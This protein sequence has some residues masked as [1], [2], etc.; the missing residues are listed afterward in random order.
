[1]KFCVLGPLSVVDDQGRELAAGQPLQQALLAMLVLHAGQVVPVD[2][3]IDG[4]WGGSAPASAANSIQVYVSRLRK[5]LE[6]NAQIATVGPGYRLEVPLEAVDA[7]SFERLASEARGAL[8]RG[9]TAK[10]V[11]TFRRALELRR[12]RPLAEFGD[13]PFAVGAARRLCRMID[14]VEED[15][16]D[17]RLA[18]GQHD[19]LP[20]E[21]EGL[22]TSDPLSERR[23]GQLMTALYLAGRQ[24]EALE[25][26]QRAREV[27]VGR[28]GVEPG[29][30]L[31]R[32]EAEVLN[33]TLRQPRPLPS[34]AVTFFLTDVEGSVRMWERAPDAMAAAIARH[35][36][37]ARE[38]I[39]AHGGLLRKTR[40]EGDSTFSVFVSAVDAVRA[41]C[42]LELEMAAESWPRSTPLRVR[43]AVHTGEA[44]LRDADYYG[45]A[46]NRAARIRSVARGEQ[47]L[48]SE[49]TAALVRDAL[50]DEI[51]V[52]DL[53]EHKL[54]DLARPER[55]FQLIGPGLR[56]DFGPIATSEP[57]VAMPTR[58]SSFV[59]RA[60]EL[61]ELAA[62]LAESR[63]VTLTGAGGCGKT[64]LAVAVATST[65]AAHA[66]GVVFV[67]LAAVGSGDL[68]PDAFA[69]ALG[70]RARPGRTLLDSVG[71]YL[72]PQSCLVVVDNCEHVAD[73]ARAVIDSALRAGSAVRVLATSRE[74]LGLAGEVTWLVPPL[75]RE[76]AVELFSQRARAA[77]PGFD[78]AAHPE[79]IGSL[80]ERLDGIP[81]AI[82]L[83]A[84]RVN[85]LSVDQIV[86]R[87]DDA[88]RFLGDDRAPAPTR[89]RTLRATCEW[90][91]ALLSG[92][93]QQLFSCLAVFAG[94][95]TLEAVE[96]LGALTDSPRDDVVGYFVRLVDK[97]LVLR[98]DGPDPSQARYRMLEPLR[99]FAYEQLAARGAVS[100][101]RDLHL[102]YFTAFAET[103]EPNLY[104]SGARRWAD[105]LGCES[106]NI[107]ASLDW[108]FTGD[109]D[110]A[111]GVRIVGALS[112]AWFAAGRIDEGREWSLAAIDACRGE[113]SAQRAAALYA[114]A[115]MASARSDLD[116]VGALSDEL[117]QLADEIESP[118][119]AALARDMAGIVCWATGEAAESVEL[120]RSAMVLYDQ[121]GDVF[122][123][124]LCC[125]EVG[126]SLAAAGRDDE[127]RVAFAEAEKRARAVGEDSALGFALDGSAV[128]SLR[129][130]DI[131]RAA[132]L[133][134]EAVDHYNASGYQEGVASG[135]NT[136]AAIA[137]ALGDLDAA[138]ADFAQAIVLCRRLGHIG[139]AATS[140]DGLAHIAEQQ[141]DL[142]GAVER[143]AAADAWREQ[144]GL[145]LPPPEARN[146][147]ALVERLRIAV[148]DATFS[149][150]WAAGAS[151][152]FDDAAR[153]GTGRR[154]V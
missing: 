142:F 23:W 128:F 75:D 115:L 119:F 38:V 154:E 31:R 81:L 98:T 74:H 24:A 88:L 62:M 111:L 80:C 2:T 123:A 99:Q 127:A 102:A 152:R 15:L 52:R 109:G 86:E 97:S 12:G 140:L 10:A 117:W 138:A 87:L 126:R 143:C 139:G 148:P 54:R 6:P 89:Q 72:G 84:A 91:Y 50:S 64:S 76:F 69:S 27:L 106:A 17:A 21:V 51:G 77:V 47:V 153:L 55:L 116:A 130:G 36:E 20:A 45:P 103:I 65:A 90:S 9:E 14:T 149:A 112:W 124:A 82:E 93:E 147:S 79:T 104:R 32:I 43:A 4:L 71:E 40:G 61:G 73:A 131:G 53:G 18:G 108:A 26:F 135:L 125:T 56:D 134:G 141:G 114:A 59:G 67:D 35:D 11:E 96:A 30:D 7:F 66:D 29:P 39:E 8:S 92:A 60:R 101:A 19:D 136:R 110:R 118:R 151:T 129:T 49:V 68:V 113:R 34:G 44:E 33:Q 78:A 70:V 5:L 137:V 16:I 25:A 100:T 42:A 13:R 121:S 122:D 150:A 63:L 48:V 58:S 144:A 95:F 132:A 133:I 145:G 37:I 120:M 46:V 3:L 22:V 107:D 105:R 1:M 28:L 146:R 83:A 85:V 57:R 41:A 94:G